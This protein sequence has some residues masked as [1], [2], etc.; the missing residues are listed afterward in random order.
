MERG[1]I[2][3]LDACALESLNLDDLLFSLPTSLLWPFTVLAGAAAPR[4]RCAPLCHPER[5]RSL[6]C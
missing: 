5:S 1:A 6:R 4:Q 3:I 2:L